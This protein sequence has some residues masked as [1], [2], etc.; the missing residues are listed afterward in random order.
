[1]TTKPLYLN[2]DEIRM[3]FNMIEK[4]ERQF[5]NLRILRDKPLTPEF[6]AGAE[7][8]RILHQKALSLVLE[9]QA[10]KGQ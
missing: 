4:T 5:G 7:T 10:E 3:L 9:F 6:Q 8:C 2:H 1:M